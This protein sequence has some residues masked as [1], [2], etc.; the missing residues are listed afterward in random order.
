[1]SQESDLR[2]RAEQR[3]KYFEDPNYFRWS[4]VVDREDES[5]GSFT[6]RAFLAQYLSQDKD[7]SMFNITSLVKEFINNH[8]DKQQINWRA[9]YKYLDERDKTTPSWL[10]SEVKE[11]HKILDPLREELAPSVEYAAF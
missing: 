2:F 11:I 8:R 1:M 10:S 3:A 4:D 7:Y 5:Y 6:E 9:I